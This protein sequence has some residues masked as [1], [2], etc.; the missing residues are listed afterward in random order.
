MNKK[1]SIL[2]GKK[3]FEN[4]IPFIKPYLPN[5][6]YY[7]D[8]FKGIINSGMLS[9]G[10]YLKEY[11]Q[12][13]SKYLNVENISA[14]SSGTI[15]LILTLESFDI[16]RGD[17]VIVPSFTF[18]ATAHA[19][20]KVGA[21]P[22]FVDCFKDT[23]TIDHTKI[24][25]EINENTKA[26]LAVHIFGVPANGSELER[27]AKHHDLKLVFDAA[28]AM[29]TTVRNKSVADMGDASVYSTSPTKTLV[30]GEGGLV[31]TKHRKLDYKISVLREYGNAG[32][33]DCEYVGINGRLNENEALIGLMSLDV[34]EENMQKR[35]KLGELYCKLLSEI[36]GITVQQVPSDVRTTYK[37]IA[38]LVDSDRFGLD[39]NRLANALNAEGIPTRFYF[40]PPLH[41]MKCYSEYKFLN[42]PITDYISDNIICLPFFAEMSYQQI[43]TIVEA[44]KDIRD[45]T[46]K[47]NNISDL[48]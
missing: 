6:D 16:G 7:Q 45:N 5:F 20:M 2:G 47:I 10:K 3:K 14:V 27:I 17:E 46:Y 18:C 32:D 1:P 4:N 39:R 25:P 24:E 15:G 40:N 44:I 8:E 28:H 26:I 23:F 33:Y 19:I 41:R 9:K 13:I 22:V 34:L 12:S 30:T 31:V 38:I 37:D 42:L 11:E 35:L 43:E 29:G 36:P 48:N 21:K